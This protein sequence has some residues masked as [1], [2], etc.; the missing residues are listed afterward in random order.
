M[1]SSIV[2]KEYPRRLY[3]PGTPLQNRSLNHNCKLTDFGE[4][5]DAVGKE[6]Y[7][8]VMNTSQVGV[9]LKFATRR[10]I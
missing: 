5:L 9:I 10:Y 3:P 2:K 6:V 8:K 4:L 7:N 1:G